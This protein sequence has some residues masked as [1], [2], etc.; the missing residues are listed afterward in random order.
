MLKK[1]INDTTI[2]Y[3]FTL[4]RWA[5]VL[6]IGFLSGSFVYLCMHYLSF[7]WFGW[8]HIKGWNTMPFVLSL[9][10]Q[11]LLGIILT[12]YLLKWIKFH[13]KQLR[14]WSYPSI[15]YA[16]PFGLSIPFFVE[17]II[18]FS[19]NDFDAS[20]A[21][22]VFFV[23][24]W[25][26]DWFKT[27]ASLFGFVLLLLMLL[28]C[29]FT[30]VIEFFKSRNRYSAITHKQ[31]ETEA[32]LTLDSQS[33]LATKSFED[34]LKWATRKE[35]PLNNSEEDLFDWHSSVERMSSLLS[36]DTNHEHRSVALIGD[37]GSGKSTLVKMAIN[38]I[39]NSKFVRV[40]L[41]C[42]GFENEEKV[43]EYILGKMLRELSYF[44]DVLAFSS[45]PDDFVQTVATKDSFGATIM[46]YFNKQCS[47]EEALETIAP[48]LK[49]TGLKICLIIEDA[50]RNLDKRIV[51][52][53]Q[54][55][56]VRVNQIEGIHFILTT[57]IKSID[58]SVSIDYTKVCEHLE[59][60]RHL[61]SGDVLVTLDKLF[62][63]M[64]EE[65]PA[66]C[67]FREEAFSLKEDYFLNTFSYLNPL[68]YENAIGNAIFV[69]LKT[70][71]ALKCVF[72]ETYKN[73]MNLKG[74]HKEEE[75]LIV[76]I[77]KICLPEVLDFMINYWERVNHISNANNDTLN[78]VEEPI[79]QLKAE[80]KKIVSKEKPVKVKAIS[81][82]VH[83]LNPR[84]HVVFESS[85]YS[86]SDKH[87]QKVYKRPIERWQSLVQG[88][89]SDN[90][91]RD[92]L[93]RQVIEKIKVG[94]H[95]DF[96]EQYIFESS[97]FANSL[98]Y[99]ISFDLDKNKYLLELQKRLY[100]YSMKQKGIEADT[101]FNGFIELRDM[102]RQM[103]TE[104]WIEEQV[105]NCLPQHLLLSKELFYSWL[106]N[107]KIIRVFEK[108]LPSIQKKRI[109]KLKDAWHEKPANDFI[110]CLSIKS[111]WA[112]SRIVM[113]FRS[114]TEDR[115]SHTFLIDG[116]DGIDATNW[117]W[118]TDVFL[119]ALKAEPTN[120][121]LIAVITSLLYEDRVDS[122]SDARSIVEIK[123]NEKPVS[124]LLFAD[125]KHSVFEKIKTAY[126]T[127]SYTPIEFSSENEKKQLLQLLSTKG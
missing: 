8:L 104:K 96:V 105:V 126:Q 18:Y 76:A 103:V 89:I 99:M 115:L 46:G 27:N 44:V 67:K 120:P 80:W 69:I 52:K 6:L 42:W 49:T 36:P 48:L 41:S 71:R 114:A 74:E 34:L 28:Y 83:E 107:P 113:P 85:R 72:Y 31:A 110:Q 13:F 3:W 39:Q 14:C 51:K 68:D 21:G 19:N 98:V 37:Y 38:K 73:W 111:Y 59:F 81:T 123:V 91:V 87:P 29:G 58:S 9:S 4:K 53:L 12:C 23:K 88:Y 84:F 93:I 30:Y 79:K 22:I 119:K 101:R 112:L 5:Y 106:L 15:L 7:E 50:D 64:H 102:S 61:R 43:Q 82:L 66:V 26:F 92:V 116:K 10:L 65:I 95:T 60:M 16:V 127:E 2:P 40:E 75:V 118:L 24:E 1:K 122:D 121:E 100:Q 70:P 77:L 45:L 124:D 55:F 35:A 117:Q 54:A 25:K 94:D 33:R 63:K 86:E 32:K 97:D 62:A 57:K 78:Q 47:P 17:G 108:N 90:I 11:L 125:N 109:E 56:L 20:L